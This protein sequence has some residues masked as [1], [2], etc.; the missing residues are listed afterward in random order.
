MLNELGTLKNI[1][2]DSLFAFLNCLDVKICDFPVLGG[3]GPL[4]RPKIGLG[5]PKI[6][7]LIDPQSIPSKASKTG[8][9]LL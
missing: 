8:L 9:T 4:G 6:L 1:H 5:G 7:E 3:P 2:F